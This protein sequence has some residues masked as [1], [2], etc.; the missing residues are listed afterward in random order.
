MA[1][2]QGATRQR[3][4]GRSGEATGSNLR[5]GCDGYGGRR[6]DRGTR[7]TRMAEPAVPATVEVRMPQMGETVTEGTI[8]AWLKAPGRPHRRR[9]APA[10][11]LHRQGR[12]RDPLPRRR[13]GR[14][15]ARPRGRHRPH[16]R[17]HRP[18]H[19]RRRRPAPDDERSRRAASRSTR[20]NRPSWHPIGSAREPERQRPERAKRRRRRVP[21]PGRAAAGGRARRGPGQRST[22]RGRDG[23]VT[24]DDV[25]ALVE[26]HPPAADRPGV[27]PRPVHG[28]PAHDRPQPRRLAG[29]R[30]PHPR[31]RRGRL[32]PGRAG[33]GARPA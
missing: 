1:F 15:G 21:L 17:A 3:G 24:R 28:H 23:R 10:G 14:R 8:T 9:R 7:G 4:T 26:A 30:G 29:H 2:L 25:L 13:R 18:H 5:R 20:R 27:A 19:H 11:D 33:E 6:E 32:R 31:R 22:G 16:R 12:L